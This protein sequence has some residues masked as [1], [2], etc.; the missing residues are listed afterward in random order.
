MCAQLLS[1][2]EVALVFLMIFFRLTHFSKKELKSQ[3]P[4]HPTSEEPPPHTHTQVL[5]IL[6]PQQPPKNKT[7]CFIPFFPSAIHWIP[8]SSLSIKI[9]FHARDAY[10]VSVYWNRTF[11]LSDHRRQT[12][13]LLQGAH[14]RMHQCEQ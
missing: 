9:I 5:K 1:L 4:F 14:S 10:S 7:R 2:L 11:F 13:L 6:L 3:L 8:D 12:K